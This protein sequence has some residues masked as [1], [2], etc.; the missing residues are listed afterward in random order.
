ML[1]SIVP[2]VLAHLIKE[3]ETALT[4]EIDC[5]IK[6]EQSP[7]KRSRD[8]VCCLQSLGDYEALLNPPEPVI[9]A[10]NQ[11]AAKAMMFITGINIEGMP[12]NCCK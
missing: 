1:L 10:A 4:A 3:E 8:L 9:S 6:K 12:I 2:L 7:G 11:A 5:S